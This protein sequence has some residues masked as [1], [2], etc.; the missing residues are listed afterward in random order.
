MTQLTIPLTGGAVNSHQRFSI[1]LGDNLLEF[2]VDYQQTVQWSIDMYQDGELLAAGAMLEPNANVFEA[3]PEL[4]ARVGAFVFTGDEVTLD[5]L[6]VDNT[7]T[8]VSPDEL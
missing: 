6:G 4:T 3:W 8:W 1:Q 2:K 5:N 7:L